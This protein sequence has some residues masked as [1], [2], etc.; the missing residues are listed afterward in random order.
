M[1]AM[2]AVTLVF[3]VGLIVWLVAHL[4]GFKSVSL[5][6]KEVGP[7]RL[8]FQHHSG[9]Y[10]K[11]EPV[12]EA[13]ETWAHANSEACKQSFGEYIDNPDTTDEDRLNSNGGCIVAG[14]WSA[15][16]LPKDFSYRE[17]PKRQFVVASF[18]G[19]PSIGPIKVYPK[20][21]KFIEDQGLKADGPVIETYET[22][23][24]RAVTTRYY[25]PVTKDSPTK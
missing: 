6:V 15:K 3:I 21:E 4:G 12:I 2:I 1:K 5:E 25:F 8:V 20:V 23:S 24:E 13:V 22:E 18:E 14:D 16:T 7:M 17:I 19:A 11:I 9:A 10:H